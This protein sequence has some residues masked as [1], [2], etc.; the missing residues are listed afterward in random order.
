MALVWAGSEHAYNVWNAKPSQPAAG[1]ASATTEPA[2]GEEDAEA[3]ELAAEPEASTSLL[4]RARSKKTTN[5]KFIHYYMLMR[6]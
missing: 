5:I 1:D 4:T 3:E 6:G 2:V